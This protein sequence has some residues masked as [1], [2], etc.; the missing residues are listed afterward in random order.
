MKSRTCCQVPRMSEQC[1]HILKYIKF[2]TSTEHYVYSQTLD[3]SAVAEH[4]WEHGHDKDFQQHLHTGQT[5]EFLGMED[6][7]SNRNLP[8]YEQH[9]QRERIP[10]GHHMAKISRQ[11]PPFKKPL[12]VAVGKK[13]LSSCVKCKMRVSG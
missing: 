2:H 13:A 6:S 1:S 8:A 3:K 12:Y 5:V 7:G 10:V 4:H 11:L 9:K